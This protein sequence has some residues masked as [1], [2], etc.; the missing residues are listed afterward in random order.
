MVHR[1]LAT[2]AFVATAA[3]IACSERPAQDPKVDDDSLVIHNPN[4]VADTRSTNGDIG[5]RQPDVVGSGDGI[6]QD[7]SGSDQVKLTDGFGT[8]SPWPAA[9]TLDG[10]DLG[11]AQPE[12][13]SF[14]IGEVSCLF[15]PQV[16]QFEPLLECFW[17]DPE[18]YTKH[19]DVVMAPVVANLTDDN[20]DGIIDVHDTPDIAFASYRYQQDGCCKSPSVLR[21]VSGAC[22]GGFTGSG[23]EEQRLHEHYHIASPKLDNSAGLAVGDL[24][25]DGIPDIVGHTLPSGTVA[26]SGAKYDG[27]GPVGQADAPTGWVVYGAPDAVTAL[28]EEVPDEASVMVSNASGS[29]ALFGWSWPLTSKAIATVRVVAYTRSEGGAGSLAGVLASGANQAVA[30]AKQVAPTDEY[31]AVV[32]DFPRNPFNNGLQWQDADL[33]GLEFGL[34]NLSPD[35]LPVYVTKLDV[36][37]GHVQQLWTSPHPKGN[38]LVTAAQPAIADL[39]KD[40]TAE[41][42][43]GRVVLDGATGELKWKGAGGV[44]VNSFFGPISVAADVNLDDK[45]EVVAGN[46]LYDHAGN[47]LWTYDYGSD[48]TGCSSGGLPCDGFNAVGDFDLDPFAEVVLVR[49]GV[50]Y[51][52]QH[53]GDLMARISLP[54][55][56]CKYNEGGPPTVADFDA[57]GRPEIGVAG[58]DFYIVFDLDCCADFPNCQNLPPEAVE[59]DSPG[60]RWKVPNNDCSSR[61]TGSSVFDFDGDG[62]AEVVYNDET[63]FRILRGSDGKI[64]FE[65]PNASHTRLE[66]ALVADCDSDANAEIV[67]VENAAGNKDPTPLQVWGDSFDNWVPTRRIWNQHSY[68]ITNITEGGLLPPGGEW[69]NWL[70]FNNFRQNLPDYDP[71]LAPDLTASVIA[72]D[73]ASCPDSATLRAEVCNAGQIWVPPGVHVMFI[74]AN[75]NSVLNCLEGGSTGVTLEPGECTTVKCLIP[76]T[77]TTPAGLWL[78]VCADD[79]DS[80][81]AGPGLQNEC[82]EENNWAAGNVA[83]C[84]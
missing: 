46:T 38:D 75:T 49:S 29:S 6:A 81:C 8:D 43:I 7:M 11:S 25:D 55:D 33:S 36:V 79:F 51:V 66:Y 71:F 41:V 14:D 3:L 76:K 18:E 83:L 30:E 69:P 77:P 64:L 44:G 56:N 39:E 31:E 45:L 34:V 82:N 58:A 26:F 42:V 54:K 12:T 32:F 37:V 53:T 57:D 40:G 80:Q 16:G 10:S 73:L 35:G 72:T 52:V 70:T 59:C 67:M 4:K 17:D 68:H 5:S 84:P 19:D 48:G 13:S 15:I 61:V 23:G 28:A 47:I 1:H 20:F 22:S 60:I 65:E 24:N 63:L 27:F 74:D 78:K 50:M 21:V 9:E 2:A 62:A